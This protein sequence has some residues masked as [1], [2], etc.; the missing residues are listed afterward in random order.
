[1]NNQWSEFLGKITIRQIPGIVYYPA[2]SGD[3]MA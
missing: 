3:I 1:M 2:V